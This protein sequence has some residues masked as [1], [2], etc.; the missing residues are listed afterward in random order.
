M[1]SNDYGIYLKLNKFTLISVESGP[2]NFEKIFGPDLAVWTM[3]LQIKVNNNEK[4]YKLKRFIFYKININYNN[5]KKIKRVNNILL[6][7]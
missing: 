5:I 1:D 6:K 7:S 2:L 3:V 4:T